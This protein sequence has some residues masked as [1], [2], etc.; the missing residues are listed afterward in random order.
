[1]LKNRPAIGIDLDDTIAN[2]LA[3]IIRYLK[4]NYD[5]DL[6]HK[7]G[8]GPAQADFFGITNEQNNEMFREMWDHPDEIKLMDKNI[9]R[10]IQ[11]LSKDYELY[12][13]TATVAP[14]ESYTKWLLEHDIKFDNVV[15]VNRSNKKIIYGIKLGIGYYIDDFSEVAKSVADAGKQALLFKR[16]WN[17]D[18]ADHN[19]NPLIKPVDNWSDIKEYFSDMQSSNSASQIK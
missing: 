9:P 4:E 19:E 1:M 3:F 10:I 7:H 2:G 6:T 16:P 14:K 8:N 12:L 13:V 15:H 5:I 18:F 11:F 17:I